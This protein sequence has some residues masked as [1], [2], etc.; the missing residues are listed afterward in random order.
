MIEVNGVSVSYSADIASE[1]LMDAA[2]SCCALDDITCSFNPGEIVSL[3]GLNGSGKSTLS[4]LLCAMRLPD[5]GTVLVDGVNPAD[6]ERERL[7]VRASVGFVQQDP[8][9]QIVSTLVF[10]EVAFGPRNL[11]LD[12]EEIAGRVEGSLAAVGLE[13]FDSRDV[14]GLSGGEQ[15]RLALAG[16]LAMDPAYLV[17]DEATSHLDS[18]AR[19]AFRALVD[20]LAHRRGLG[21][22]QVTHD[23]VELLASDRVVV[24]EHGKVVW[25]GEPERLLIDRRD[26]WDSLTLESLYVSAV[27]KALEAGVDLSCIRSPQRLLSWL[28][29]DSVAFSAHRDVLGPLKSHSEGPF[30]DRGAL[31][32]SKR[33]SS[34]RGI[35]VR[36]VS[37]SYGS[38]R[39][40]LDSVSLTASPGRITLLAGRSGSGKSTLAM[41]LAGLSDPD[42]GRIE[43]DGEPPAPSRC[44]LAFQRPENQLFLQT[45]RDEIA[46]APRNAGVDEGDLDARVRS[47]A[48]R[49]GLEEDLLDRSP[50]ELSG[51]Q[52]RRVGLA[53]VLSL[54]AG[55]YVFDEPTAGL[56]APGRLHLHQLVRDLA[57]EGAAVV[58]ITHD[59]DEWI[60]DVDDVALMA[61]GSISWAGAAR[62]L[63]N[64]PA[65][66]RA[67]GIEP[68]ESALLLE[69]LRG[70]AAVDE[71]EEVGHGEHE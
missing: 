61:D 15:Q 24:L 70:V 20:S 30:A 35:E 43:V 25:Q 31:E 69:A 42:A 51:G 34:R 11:G 60:G 33:R 12:E 66:Y 41:L 65:V 45:V 71:A 39:P 64:E 27:E 22:V 10:D 32:R 68:P 5:T 8:V 56:D 21:I 54:S 1:P 67:A 46:F 19:P 6:G 23:P 29:K 49:V 62:E 14:N 2:P 40:V 4:R 48:D 44:G 52:A 37:F 57:D 58:L 16:V 53:C 13:G 3:A 17:L 50:F 9:D 59:L 55:A 63:W 26:L 28:Q 36:G 38:T 7:A 18:A 47:I